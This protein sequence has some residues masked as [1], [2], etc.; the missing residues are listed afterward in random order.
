M[1]IHHLARRCKAPDLSMRLLARQRAT[2]VSPLPTVLFRQTTPAQERWHRTISTFWASRPEPPPHFRFGLTH[3]RIMYQKRLLVKSVCFVFLF[4][5]I[6]NK[7]YVEESST[8]SIKSPGWHFNTWQ[9]LSIDF[10]V[11]P[12]F[13]FLMAVNVLCPSSPSFR[14]RYV[15]YPRSFNR[16]KSLSYFI[17][18]RIHLLS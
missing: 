11:N 5:L 9:S 17:D 10:S 8:Y 1:I 4:G 2:W 18:I 15:V 12:P 13:P 16:A 3:S 6:I 7:T 14:I